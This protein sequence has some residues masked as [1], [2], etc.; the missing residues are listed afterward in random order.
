MFLSISYDYYKVF[1]QVAKYGNITKAAKVLYLT[2]ST[3]SRTIQHLEHE[4]GCILLSHSTQ[5]VKL[6]KE[7]EILYGHLDV[8]F[9][10]I[11][12]AEERLNNMRR[13][14]EGTLRVGASELTLEFY[15]LPY[16]E[17][18]KREHPKINVRLSYSNPEQAVTDLNTGLLD[19]AIL[20]SPLVK[21]DSSISVVPLMEINYDLAGGPGFAALKADKYNLCDLMKYPFVCM[22]KGMSV[23]TYADQLLTSIN[24]V[25]EPEFEVGSMPLL[26]SIIQTN[27]ALGFAP[28]L[29]LQKT[30]ANDTLFPIRLYQELPSENICLLTSN[31][32]PGNSL[33]TRF[34]GILLEK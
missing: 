27:L 4:L 31:I 23:R 28:S 24:S 17:K 7:G 13:L 19:I 8:A 34:T 9:G 30:F 12:S 26:I 25:L 15:L 18:F 32:L 21:I 20:A 16:L 1:F 6:T 10:H 33:L 2:Q 22:E 3:V 11:R 14:N 29:H 5:G